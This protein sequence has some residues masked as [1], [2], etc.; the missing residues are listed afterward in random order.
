[1]LELCSSGKLLKIALFPPCKMG[2]TQ[3]FLFHR[4]IL[5]MKWRWGALAQ[6]ARGGLGC[7]GDLQGPSLVLLASSS[8]RYHT[9]PSGDRNGYSRPSD[10]LTK[11][12]PQSPPA[13]VVKKRSGMCRRNFFRGNVV[14]WAG[15]WS[16]QYLRSNPICQLCDWDKLLTLSVPQLSQYKMEGNVLGS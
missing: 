15:I 8:L 10:S 1:M 2:R 7:V 12:C 13:S 5:K 6:G 16:Q 9:H 4:V 14:E 3:S 11:S